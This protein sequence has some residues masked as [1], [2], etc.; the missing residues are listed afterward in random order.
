M[1]V[2]YNLFRPFTLSPFPRRR[3]RV[4][5]Q[6]RVSL[7]HRWQ[8]PTWR[9]SIDLWL[10]VVCSLLFSGITTSAIIAKKSGKLCGDMREVDATNSV[11][12]GE[13]ISDRLP[14]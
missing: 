2:M 10:R 14:G 1:L 12:C 4:L 11:V 3:Q 9:A 7:P 6:H 8:S 13:I 5:L